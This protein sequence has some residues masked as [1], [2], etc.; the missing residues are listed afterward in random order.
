MPNRVFLDEGQ[1][2]QHGKIMHIGWTVASD[3]R[4]Y[5]QCMMGI[6]GPLYKPFEICRPPFGSNFAGVHLLEAEH[7]SP[8]TFEL[9]GSTAARSSKA[10]PPFRALPKS[11]RLKLAIRMST[12]LRDEVLR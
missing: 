4:T 8:E 3:A 11:S 12:S 6:G 7:V 5:R 10:A 9:G 2:A 1:P